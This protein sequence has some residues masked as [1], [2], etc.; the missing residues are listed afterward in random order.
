MLVI[1]ESPMISNDLLFNIYL[2][3]VEIFGC[4]GWRFL[5][6]CH[7]YNQDQSICTLGIIRITL[8]HSGGNLK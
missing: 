4:Q 8:N 6:N 1:D 7:Q 3:L 2:R 5:S